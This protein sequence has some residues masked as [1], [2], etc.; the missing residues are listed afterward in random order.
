MSGLG[1]VCFF[2]EGAATFT[3]SSEE[4]TAGKAAGHILADLEVYV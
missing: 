4:M 2:P 3:A 1:S